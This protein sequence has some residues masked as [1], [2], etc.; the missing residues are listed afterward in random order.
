MTEML[1]ARPVS[2]LLPPQKS[3]DRKTIYHLPLTKTSFQDTAQWLTEIQS[4]IR[5]SE[6][7]QAASLSV[8]HSA[9]TKVIQPSIKQPNTAP[10][11]LV[12]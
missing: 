8:V 2:Q 10:G 11:L 12:V 3:W 4:G 7:D 6:T 1:S 5:M 9:G